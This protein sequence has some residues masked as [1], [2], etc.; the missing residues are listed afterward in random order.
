MHLER[1]FKERG[2]D[3]TMVRPPQLTDKPYTGKYRVREGGLPIFD[4]KSR[5]PMRPIS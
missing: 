3:W 2:L 1:L 5:V 4:L